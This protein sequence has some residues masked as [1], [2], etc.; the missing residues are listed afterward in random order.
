MDYKKL[1]IHKIIL[2]C[3]SR[4]NSLKIYGRITL[5]LSCVESSQAI[6]HK[7]GKCVPSVID[8]EITDYI[9]L[10][11]MSYVCVL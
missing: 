9:L 1:S 8:R 11:Y 10:K 5:G 2:E 4:K 3:L 7:K 6:L